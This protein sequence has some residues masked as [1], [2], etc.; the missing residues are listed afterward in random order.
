MKFVV[1]S[2]AWIE[3]LDGTMMGETVKKI[4]KGDNEF[5]TL[6]LIVS[7]V[8]SRVKRMDQDVDVAYNAIISNSKIIQLDSEFSKEAGLLHAKMNKEIKN[9]GLVDSILLLCARKL[10][11]KIVTG[12]EHFRNVKEAVLIK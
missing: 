12:D 10:R 6:S 3:Y 7:E 9:F 4:L 1:D 8:I 2:Y 11:A 5:Y